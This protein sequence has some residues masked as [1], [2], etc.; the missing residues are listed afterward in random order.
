[1][2]HVTG[3]RRPP[4]RWS[5]MHVLPESIRKSC[6]L[7]GSIRYAAASPGGALPTAV[8]RSNPWAARETETGNRRRRARAIHPG[9][10]RRRPAEPARA[11][12][13]RAAPVAHGPVLRRRV[14]PDRTGRRPA[15]PCG[16]GTRPLGGAPA[17]AGERLSGRL[18]SR[19]V[20]GPPRTG[21]DHLARRPPAGHARDLPCQEIDDLVGAAHHAMRET[22]HN[23]PARTVPDQAPS[24]HGRQRNEKAGRA[25]NAAPRHRIFQALTRQ[26]PQAPPPGGKSQRQARHPVHPPTGRHG[27][28]RSARVPQRLRYRAMH[29]CRRPD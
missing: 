10:A 11:H 9:M 16:R 21:R 3:Q 15:W 28:H 13:W 23:G 6:V 8:S 1:M 14:D 22:M 19:T 12:A 24:G 26:R 17:L 7:S 2:K 4:F 20:D 18:H 27:I 25:R 29:R 5:R